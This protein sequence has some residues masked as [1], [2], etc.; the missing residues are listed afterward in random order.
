MKEF[1]IKSNEIIKRQSAMKEQGTKFRSVSSPNKN[2]VKP[3]GGNH[4]HPGNKHY[5]KLTDLHKKE[6]VLS[7]SRGK[8]IIVR[9]I[10]DQIAQLSPPGR[11]LEKSTDGN[12]GIKDKGSALKK[13]KKALSENNATIIEYLKKRGQLTKEPAKK[14]RVK[15]EVQGTKLTLTKF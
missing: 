11:F 15:T 2:D 5:I 10:Y 7:D 1:K 8:A 4:S 13:I 3:G 9:K 6:F 14:T 12:W